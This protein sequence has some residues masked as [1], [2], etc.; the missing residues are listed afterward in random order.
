MSEASVTCVEM[1]VEEILVEVVRSDIL[2]YS[3]V[4]I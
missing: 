3:Q 2:R 1:E 4:G